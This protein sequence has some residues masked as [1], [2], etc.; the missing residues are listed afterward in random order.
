MYV[1][2]Q[3]TRRGRGRGAGWICRDWV[4]LTIRVS[5]CEKKMW[6]EEVGVGRRKGRVCNA[7]KCE[8]NLPTIKRTQS[9]CFF[10]HLLLH[11]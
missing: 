6:R 4:D 8:P 3:R 1:S 2:A 5:L 10:H 9:K 11:L 7:N